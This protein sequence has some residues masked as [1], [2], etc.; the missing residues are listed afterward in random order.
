[1]GLFD[2]MAI[3]NRARNIC[4]LFHELERLINTKGGVNGSNYYSVTN[5]I[6]QIESEYNTM[7]Q[8][9]FNTMAIARQSPT[10]KWTDGRTYSIHEWE[11][12]MYMSLGQAKVLVN[13]YRQTYK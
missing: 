3:K 6:S 10:L 9:L 8:A 4:S 11:G 1:M 2:S 5:T 13:Q 7:L 12:F